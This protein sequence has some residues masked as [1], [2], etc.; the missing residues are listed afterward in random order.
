MSTIFLR[1]WDRASLMYSSI[2]IKMLRYTMIHITT[3]ALHV[4][5]GSSVHHQEL[6]AVYTASGICRV[7]TSPYRLRELELHF[8]LTQAVR[9]S[10][11]STNTRRY[12]YSFELLM[13]GGGTA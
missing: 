3:N 5:V 13:T 9:T 8:Q 2:T 11:N 12:V 6:N 4:S 1:S 10:K 7:F